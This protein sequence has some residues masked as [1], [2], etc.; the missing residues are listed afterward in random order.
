MAWLSTCVKRSTDVGQTE[1]HSEGHAT[2]DGMLE[3]LI[4]GRLVGVG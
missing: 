3:F 4:S 1:D 2:R